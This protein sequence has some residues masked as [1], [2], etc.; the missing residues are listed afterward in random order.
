MVWCGV[1]FGGQRGGD[2]EGRV[3][4][5]VWMC[6]C[7]VGVFGALGHALHLPLFEADCVTAHTDSLVSLQCC[8]PLAPRTWLSDDV[9][10]PCA[11]V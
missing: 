7:R 1:V 6:L 5:G 8:S 3:R 10:T 4:E 11:S 2:S 9:N